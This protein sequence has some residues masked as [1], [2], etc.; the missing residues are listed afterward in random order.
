MADANLHTAMIPPKLRG[1]PNSRTV[2][3]TW[4]GSSV[5]WITSETAPSPEINDVRSRQNWLLDD[6]P[7]LYIS[8]HGYCFFIPRISYTPIIV[9]VVALIKEDHIGRL[10]A[11]W[12]TGVVLI[13][14]A[15]LSVKMRILV[16]PFCVIGFIE[17]IPLT[18]VATAIITPIVAFWAFLHLPACFPCSHCMMKNHIS[19]RRTRVLS[20]KFLTDEIIQ[21][22]LWIRHCFLFDEK[23]MFRRTVTSSSRLRQERWGAFK[24]RSRMCG[25]VF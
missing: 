5:N 6:I 16:S 18:L 17:V 21:L 7:W 13:E 15:F 2:H 10:F 19:H 23:E 4:L 24:R 9:K 12:I 3:V 20:A 11:G 8:Y 14:V 25:A 22:G 1:K